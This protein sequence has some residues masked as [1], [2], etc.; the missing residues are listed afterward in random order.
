MF[1][2]IILLIGSETVY[3]ACKRVSEIHFIIRDGFQAFLF[4]GNDRV[5]N[6]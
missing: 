3:I 2:S 4:L 1:A 6:G 5:K